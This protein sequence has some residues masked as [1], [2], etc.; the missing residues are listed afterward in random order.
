MGHHCGPLDE[1]VASLR[2]D[3]VSDRRFVGP[4]IERNL[5]RMFGG[6]ILAQAIMA[7]GA[8]VS[9]ARVLHS[10]HALF[11]TGGDPRRPVTFVVDRVRD[12]RT[13]S[14]RSVLARQ[15]DRA[16]ACVLLSFQEHENGPE[17]DASVTDAAAAPDDLPDLHQRLAP[18]RQQLPPWWTDPYPFDIRFIDHPHA[19][20]TAGIST[21]EQR[22][23]VRTAGAAPD[24]PLVQAALLAYVS[25]LNLLDAA[26]LPHGRSWYGNRA[27][28]GASIDHAMW[29]HRPHTMD[30]WL[31]CAQRSPVAF[32]GR[33][34]CTCTFTDPSKRLV[35]SATQE[36]S[37][38]EL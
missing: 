32:G 24:E 7:A 10:L 5:P 37:L 16:L 31:L 38:R 18:D 11:L 21:P 3:H 26:L 25:D 29:F 8:T 9:D 23:W 2:V 27:I 12:G 22:F 4:V 35:A 15:A 33:S 36:G 17:H 28:G 14:A 1:L 13:Y 34:L 19:L 6:Q 30:T 20:A